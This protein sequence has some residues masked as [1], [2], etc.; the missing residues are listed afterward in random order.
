M[1]HISLNEIKDK[2]QF[3]HKMYDTVR[4]VDPIH[5]KVT[6]YIGSSLMETHE[7]C[8]NYWGDERIC[9]N[10]I[11]IRAYQE[12]RN[13]VKLEQNEETILLVTAIPITNIETPV[14]LELMKNAT[15]SMLV[16]TGTYS[17]GE[18]LQRYAR[19]INDL[20]V[21]DSLTSLYNQRFIKERLPVDIIDAT[22]NHLPLSV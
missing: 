3:F 18:P 13:F 14:V 2:L 17:E 15:D 1:E 20:I 7:I 12:D 4:L 16:G 5:K 11:S 6:D 21:R 8:Y 9:D 19:E 10:C 22:L